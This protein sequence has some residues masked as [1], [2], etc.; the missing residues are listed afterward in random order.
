MQALFIDSVMDVINFLEYC[1]W[2]IKGLFKWVVA[3]KCSIASIIRLSISV[4]SYSKPHNMVHNLCRVHKVNSSDSNDFAE[5]NPWAP[6]NARGIVL[7]E[8]VILF[9]KLSMTCN[10]L[11]IRSTDSG[12]DF[13][14]QIKMKN[15]NIEVF[16]INRKVDW[17]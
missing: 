15:T 17:L 7:L 1:N 10:D 9:L 8:S 11:T 12:D 5:M 14:K 2:L 3:W 6:V 13:A 16:H 4:F